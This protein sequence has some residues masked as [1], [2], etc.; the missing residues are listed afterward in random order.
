M[1]VRRTILR[2][3]SLIGFAV[4]MALGPLPVLAQPAPVEATQE[5]AEADAKK[6]DLD[7]NKKQVFEEENHSIYIDVCGTETSTEAQE[8]TP[9]ENG[10]G[11]STGPIGGG[12]ECGEGG[13]ANGARGSEAN[14]KQIWNFLKSKGLSDTAAAG[15][16]GNMDQESA[17]MPDAVNWIDCHGIV[18]WCYDRKD[19]ML[20]RAAKEGADWRCLDF[21]LNYMWYELTETSESQVMEPLKA[22]STAGEAAMVFARL[23]ER[24]GENEYAGRDTKAEAAYREFTGK[25]SVP[26]PESES[27]E[28]VGDSNSSTQCYSAEDAKDKEDSGDAPGSGPI[29]AAECGPLVDTIKQQVAAGTIELANGDDNL[30]KDLEK[31]TT[32][33]IECNNGV[34]PEILRT[35]SSTAANS[36]GGP[37]K[38]WSFNTGHDCDG[39][40]HPNGRAV[41]IV[42]TGNGTPG[43]TE[44]CNKQYRYLYDNAQELG[45]NDLIWNDPPPGYQCLDNGVPVDCDQVFG[46]G[47][48]TDHI[49][50]STKA[51]TRSA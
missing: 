34:S 14:K 33:P 3:A 39:G 22:A 51:N 43:N 27:A 13:Y 50:V 23:Y 10:K 20:A 40:D 1:L 30:N 19:K 35:L 32:G 18:Q 46:P 6:R 28:M 17:Y 15:I 16:M 42:C 47:D 44:E 38:M 4:L 24:P 36:G 48:H 29:P 21:Q 26:V 37:V 7:Q 49:H 25:E 45:I 11:G 12:S 41:D 5:E 31:C 9:A 8:P 2:S